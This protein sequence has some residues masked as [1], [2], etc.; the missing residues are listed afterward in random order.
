MVHGSLAARFAMSAGK[1]T[2]DSYDVDRVEV[3]P[4]VR[5]K[6]FYVFGS[7][8][9]VQLFPDLTFVENNGRGGIAFGRCTLL[10]P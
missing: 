2:C 3:D 1:I 6:K 5:I 9:D 10:A 4:V 8:F 7:Q